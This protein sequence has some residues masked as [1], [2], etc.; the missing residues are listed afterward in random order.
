MLAFEGQLLEGQ[1]AGGRLLPEERWPAEGQRVAEEQLLGELAV[2][3]RAGL[4]APQDWLA[5]LFEAD[6]RV[7]HIVVVH[8]AVA[9]VHIDYTIVVHIEVAAHI[10]YKVVGRRVAAHIGYNVVARMVADHKDYKAAEV[11]DHKGLKVVGHKVVGKVDGRLAFQSLFPPSPFL[12]LL[13]FLFPLP[14]LPVL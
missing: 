13:P 1:Q 9:A 7:D 12:L 8:R 3:F 6:T 11:A 5:E 14:F 10:G 4:V 2:G